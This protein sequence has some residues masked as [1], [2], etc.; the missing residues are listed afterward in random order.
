MELQQELREMELDCESLKYWLQLSEPYLH[1]SNAVHSVG[2]AL[3][4]ADRIMRR[5]DAIKEDK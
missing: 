4:R 1:H 5:I 2:E 3:V